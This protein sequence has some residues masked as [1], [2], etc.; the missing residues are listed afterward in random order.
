M[1]RPDSPLGCS[2]PRRQEVLRCRAA[3][4]AAAG[5]QGAAERSLESRLPPEGGAGIAPAPACT[6][7]ANEGK[8]TDLLRKDHRIMF[9]ACRHTCGRAVIFEVEP[10]NNQ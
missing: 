8:G 9:G 2:G 3:G 1:L 10:E 7:L 5:G 4:S 6:E